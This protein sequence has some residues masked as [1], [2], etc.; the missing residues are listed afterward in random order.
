MKSSTLTYE[1]TVVYE[2]VPKAR[3][4][5]Q[6]ECKHYWMIERATAA[7]SNGV[8][9]HCG[10]R[11]Q[12]L[13]YLSDC[14][15]NPDKD[16]YQEWLNRQEWQE[17]MHNSDEAVLSGLGGERS[18]SS[19]PEKSPGRRGRVPNGTRRGMTT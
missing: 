7:V 8:C 17:I 18:L 13:N 2:A 10:A 15:A 9:K 19:R 16:G 1:T 12:F 11:K 14:L 6:L 4:P 5:L 3:S